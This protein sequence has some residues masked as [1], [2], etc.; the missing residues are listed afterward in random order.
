MNASRKPRLTLLTAMV[1]FG[2]IGI[3][4]RGIPMTSAALAMVR[5]FA[6][7]VFLLFGMTMLHKKPDIIAIRQNFLLLFLSGGAMGIN[8]ILLFEA[9]HYTSV[10]VATLC[11]YMAPV[12]VILISPVLLGEKL[13]RKKGICAAAAVV[14]MV[15]ISGIMGEGNQNITGILLGLAAAGFYA[16]VVLMNKKLSGIGGLDRTVVQLG[17]AAV[18]LLP[19]VLLTGKANFEALSGTG[20]ALT[21]VVCILHTAVAY[22]LYFSAIGQLPAQTAALYSYIDPVVAV[23]LSAVVLSEKLTIWGI[24]GAVLVLGSMVVSELPEKN[25]VQVRNDTV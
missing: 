13:T 8:W 23:L 4:R 24:L 21:V 3:F 2:T 7:M 16:A 11:Y 6:G 14:G 15:F 12:F 10:A 1:I 25:T 18:V 9:Y 20:L 17:A 19:Y 5:G 22:A